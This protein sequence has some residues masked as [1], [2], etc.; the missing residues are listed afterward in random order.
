MDNTMLFYIMGGALGAFVVILIA[1]VILSKKMQKSE[2][3]RIQQLQQGT[4]ENRFSAEIL[5]QKLYL[6]Y[7]KIP[8]IKRYVLKIRRR[9][10][11]IEIDDEYK[12]R[13][14]TAI[15]L[16][17]A[18]PPQ[19]APKINLLNNFS[20][21]FFSFIYPFSS[22][23]SGSKCFLY[24]ITASFIYSLERYPSE[25]YGSETYPKE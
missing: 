15:I 10:E 9:L 12:T 11:I 13:R 25:L 8:F 23:K 19:C 2:Y 5:F 3:R 20:M 4:K 14:G 22:N 6:T 7:I 21:P 18:L 24:N 16:T 17:K 1:Y